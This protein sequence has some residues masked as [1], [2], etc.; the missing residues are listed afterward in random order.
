M[1]DDAP[2]SGG[3]STSAD[4]ELSAEQR[5]RR[6]LRHDLRN[7]LAVVLGRC[8]MLTSGAFGELDERQLRSV[9]I[10]HRNAERMVDMLEELSELVGQPSQ[11]GRGP[12][13][14]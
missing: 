2:G 6:A 8:E 10:I 7:P 12:Q 4:G 1:P 13:S 14:S 5:L 3:S 11:D 9:E